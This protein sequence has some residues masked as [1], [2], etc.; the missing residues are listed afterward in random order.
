MPHPNRSR[1]GASLS[2]STA[3]REVQLRANS[4]ATVDVVYGGRSETFTVLHEFEAIN[5]VFSS[6]KNDAFEV[7]IPKDSCLESRSA[8]LMP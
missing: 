8:C 6:I 1:S 7:G 3:D 4:R 5:G 2:R